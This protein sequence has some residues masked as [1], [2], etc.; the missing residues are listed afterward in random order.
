MGL[1][2]KYEALSTTANEIIGGIVAE[3]HGSLTQEN[4]NDINNALKLIEFARGQIKK[5]DEK[6]G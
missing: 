2:D 4:T 3:S 5:L 6:K 1:R